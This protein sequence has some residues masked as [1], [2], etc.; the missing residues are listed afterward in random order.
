MNKI[1]KKITITDYIDER[2]IL[3]KKY[4]PEIVDEKD[5]TPIAFMTKI[6]YELD[7]KL[8]AMANQKFTSLEKK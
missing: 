5:I 6:L 2:Q 1:N 4:F 7:K 3:I 8:E